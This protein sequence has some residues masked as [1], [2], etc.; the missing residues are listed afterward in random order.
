MKSKIAA[1]VER[2]LDSGIYIAMVP[3]IPGAYTHAQTLVELRVKLKEVI[4]LG[5]KKMDPNERK[6]LPVFVG[7]EEIEVEV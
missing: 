1:Y 3:G 4:E 2:D 7:V 5:L 6:S